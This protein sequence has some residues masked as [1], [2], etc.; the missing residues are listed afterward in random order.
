[1]KTKPTPC[2][3]LLHIHFIIYFR[4]VNCTATNSEFIILIADK[5]QL[6]SSEAAN[7]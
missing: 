3:Q 7:F 4:N 2:Y 1:M 6:E 5:L